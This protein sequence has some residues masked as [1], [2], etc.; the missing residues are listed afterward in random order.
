VALKT[1]ARSAWRRGQ[2]RRRAPYLA[3]E[4]VAGRSLL[5]WADERR[6]GVRERIELFLQV[7]QA[8]QYAHEQ[9]NTRRGRP[10]RA[11]HHR[12]RQW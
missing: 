6:A 1:P 8:V 2:R 11:P 12:R 5:H 4:Y 10:G 3:L 9:H 7:L